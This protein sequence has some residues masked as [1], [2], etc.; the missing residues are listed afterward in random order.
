MI[1]KIRKQALMQNLLQPT[2]KKIESSSTT[3]EYHDEKS[4]ILK[5]YLSF[6]RTRSQSMLLIQ[7]GL[8]GEDT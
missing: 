5:L 8:H 4:W 3:L 6:M 2:T 1:S 7:Q